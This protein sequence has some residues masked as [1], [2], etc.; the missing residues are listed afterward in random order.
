MN[1]ILG[2]LGDSMQQQHKQEEEKKRQ[3]REEKR[4][5]KRQ[6][7]ASSSSLPK[8]LSFASMLMGDS[9]SMT[10]MDKEKAVPVVDT[11]LKEFTIEEPSEKSGSKKN[12]ETPVDGEFTSLS[13]FPVDESMKKENDSDS[14]NDTEQTET[15]KDRMPT[16]SVSLTGEKKTPRSDDENQVDVDGTTAQMPA[17]EPPFY[18]SLWMRVFVDQ[19]YEA[20]VSKLVPK[21]FFKIRAPGKRIIDSTTFRSCIM[22]LVVL[23]ALLM[24]VEHY[25]M[26]HGLYI[27]QYVLNTIFTVFF[28]CELVLKFIFFGPKDFLK[29]RYN[30]FDVV[31]V[32]FSLIE[33]PL[34]FFLPTANFSVFRV[35]RLL[36]VLK[37][38]NISRGL[39]GVAS[40]VLS[41]LSSLMVLLMLLVFFVFITA[42][43]GMQLFGGKINLQDTRPNFDNLWA[44]MLTT[45]Q[46]CTEEN[47]HELVIVVMRDVH[48]LSAL[49]FI[50]VLIGGN[51]IVLNLFI[52]L[53]LSNVATAFADSEKSN[54]GLSP[55]EIFFR[56]LRRVRK[57]KHANKNRL[58]HPAIDDDMAP[59]LQQKHSLGHMSPADDFLTWKVVQENMRPVPKPNPIARMLRQIAHSFVWYVRNLCKLRNPFKS[60]WSLFVF[61][62]CKARDVLKKVLFHKY[63]EWFLMGLIA[64]SSVILI[65]DHPYIVPS[66]SSQFILDIFTLIFVLIFSVEAVLKIIAQG[67]ILHKGSYLRSGLNALDFLIVISGVSDLFFGLDSF[68]RFALY[69]AIR[70]SKFSRFL[71]SYRILR[72]FKTLRPI[73]FFNR[74]ESLKKV[75]ISLIS[76]I[77]SILNVF[78]IGFFVYL[79]F[80]IVGVQLFAGKLGECSD[81][82]FLTKQAC[83]AAGQDWMVSMNN[84]DNFFNACCALFESSTM[85]AYLDIL[86]DIQDIVGVDM[87]KRRD[88]APYYAL[89]MI[90]YMMF[91]T[92]MYANLLVGV[93]I[94]RYNSRYYMDPNQKEG[95]TAK[96]EEYILLSKKLQVAT[97]DYLPK[98]PHNILR[99]LIYTVVIHPIFETFIVGL[100]ILNCIF[101]SM[102]FYEMP[103]AYA[104]FLQI[105]GYLFTAVFGLEVI[106]KIFAFGFKGYFSDR[107][108]VLDFAIQV[109]SIIGIV[110]Q[111]IYEVGAFTNMFRS[112]RVIRLLKVV[113]RAKGLRTLAQTLW[114]SLPTI[115]NI[116][117]VIVLIFYIYAVLGMDLFGNGR[118]GDEVGRSNNFETVWNAF[119]FLIRMA[120]GENWNQSQ[121]D[122]MRQPPECSDK[123]GDCI[124]IPNFFIRL[125]FYSFMITSMFVLFNLFVAVVLE[126]FSIIADEMDSAITNDYVEKF[127]HHWSL[128]DE[129][130]TGMIPAVSLSILL[131]RVGPPFGVP[132]NTPQAVLIERI[133]GLNLKVFAGYI[134]FY[135]TLHSLLEYH[136]YQKLPK[137][138]QKDQHRIWKRLFSSQ[139]GNMMIGDYFSKAKIDSLDHDVKFSTADKLTKEELYFSRRG[140]AATLGLSLVA[141]SNLFG[142]EEMDQFRELYPP[143]VV[144][145]GL[146]RGASIS[147][148]MEKELKD[149]RNVAT[150]NSVG[151]V[152]ERAL[153]GRL[154][155]SDSSTPTVL[156]QL[157]SRGLVS[158][159]NLSRWFSENATVED[160]SD[161]LPRSPNRLSA[162]SSNSSLGRWKRAF[163]RET[164]L[165]PQEHLPSPIASSF[166]T[167]SSS[168]NVDDSA[169]EEDSDS[170]TDSNYA[171]STEAP[172]TSPSMQ[173][174][175]SNDS[176]GGA[177]DEI[178]KRR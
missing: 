6:F 175:V 60:D 109:S 162:S 20:I 116:L 42:L 173:I 95:L 67:F 147:S 35:L 146:Q 91:G 140:L 83:L 58:V 18:F 46:L 37:L 133:S 108:N 50:A 177:H 114:N 34:E 170:E 130:H 84:F 53:L 167:P 134:Q 152:L 21:W 145:I 40:A 36:R 57:G 16:Q 68:S 136:F 14:D 79:I 110:L 125:Y 168:Q 122:Y 159:S 47:W 66:S 156:Q 19:L 71:E 142:P 106:M 98:K 132:S 8:N 64:G 96:Q 15:T 138:V 77:P 117:V 38:A 48:P 26:P 166:H 74:I 102:E 10:S 82:S 172:L 92:F 11:E 94:D 155:V 75:F 32:V 87:A 139:Q 120:T 164:E 78:V 4:Q 28:T 157:S 153:S 154:E 149:V 33:I 105:V 70:S 121:W 62:P 97:I 119:I 80:G 112:F 163:E 24:T 176:S 52:A 7:L 61:P 54:E 135:E 29:D 104:L 169:R 171:T 76:T 43:L 90:F 174:V 111:L 103:Q 17:S 22:L 55:S 128:I 72:V 126:N 30:L 123:R 51:Y 127:I 161:E 101:M 93:L 144:D 85:E 56:W 44:A 45:F 39:K 13:M 81:E 178:P 148:S 115:L 150:R 113:K 160:F 107:W 165:T 9:E 129:E 69:R 143:V 86:Y 41:S 49:Y 118:P 25:N 3:E 2:I 124:N 73:R 141:L 12:N 1:L 31:V 23:N 89:Y 100:V 158:G 63:F 59:V 131:R 65:L 27:T 151:P 5:R 99:R 88:A 137:Q